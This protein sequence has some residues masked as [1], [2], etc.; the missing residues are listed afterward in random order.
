M[1]T[2]LKAGVI[3]LPVLV[4]LLGLRACASGEGDRWAER[5]RDWDPAARLV[6]DDDDVI[7]VAPTA[8]V[9][10]AAADELRRFIPYLADGY[11]DLLGRPKVER[12]V[13]VLFSSPDQVRA[14]AGRNQVLEPGRFTGMHGYTDPQHGALFV[15]VEPGFATL[16]HEAVHW[17]MGTAVGPHMSYSP[18]LSEGLAQ[19]FETKPPGIGPEG[20]NMMRVAFPSSDAFDVMRLVTLDDYQRFVSVNG[21]RNYAQALLLTAFLFD[22][23]PRALL[24]ELMDAQRSAVSGRVESFES[25]YRPHEPSFQRDLREFLKRTKAKQN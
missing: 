23:R 17:V 3:V 24:H 9:G 25:L 18:W 16:R 20:V 19:L 10:H 22:R 14:Y 15:P 6:V 1:T 12:V 5:A 8:A 4:I 13:A 11:G 21:G 7:V 2:L